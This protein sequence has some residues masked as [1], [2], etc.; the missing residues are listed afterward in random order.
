MAHRLRTAGPEFAENAPVRLLFT[1]VLSAP[2]EAVYRALAEETEAWPRWF[3]AVRRARPLDGGARREIRLVGGTRFLETVIVSEP[4]RRYAYRIDETN[5]PGA[6]AW[7]EDWDL[8][9]AGTGT[10]L[11]WTFAV[12]GPRGFR[13]AAR[14]AR[15]GIH[16]SFRD[17]ARN[18]ERR[19]AS[20]RA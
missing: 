12:D 13:L 5:V 18:L 3:T 10:R 20:A 4:A 15:P 7:V 19:L 8:E 11:H 9:P 14:L 6:R 17:A 2:P 16:R 1:A